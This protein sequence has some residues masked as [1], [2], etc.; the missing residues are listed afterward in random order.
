M[1]NYKFLPAES[2]FCSGFDKIGFIN[3]I[4]NK[5]SDLAN[6]SSFVVIAKNEQEAVHLVTDLGFLLKDKE[7]KY[8]PDL[9]VLAYDQE[10]PSSNLVSQRG[11]VFHSLMSNERVDI[12]VTTMG[13]LLRKNANKTHWV[14]SV[15][16]IEL[17]QIFELEKIKKGLNKINYN[18]QLIIEDFGQYS[19]RNNIF[20]VYPTGYADAF[21]VIISDSGVVS[22]IK[23]LNT[24]TQLSQPSDVKK[25]T[26][27]PVYEFPFNNDIIPEF[28]TKWRRTFNGLDGVI[29]ATQYKDVTAGVIPQ[30]ANFYMPF[31]CDGLVTLF[32]LISDDATFFFSRDSLESAKTIIDRIT[33]RYSDMLDIARGFILKPSELWLDETSLSHKLSKHN[34]Y[35]YSDNEDVNSADSISA[36]SN[37]ITRFP[38]IA[39]SVK[40]LKK[41]F[42]TA[43][44][45]LFVINSDV[46]NDSLSKLMSFMKLES[47][48]VQS[49]SE[50]E[51]KGGICVCRGLME[52]GFYDRKKSQLVITENEMYGM[53]LSQVVDYNEDLETVSVDSRYFSDLE[54]GDPIVHL[55][56]GIGRFLGFEVMDTGANL[57]VEMVKVAYQN[58][59]TKFIPPQDLDMISRYSGI[60]KDTAPFDE[61]H[62]K[63]WTKGLN[64]VVSDIA[65]ISGSLKQLHKNKQENWK[66]VPCDKPGFAYVKFCNEFPYP[67]TMDQDKAI[68]DVIAD[69]TSERVM[70][71]LVS[72]DVGYGK[73]EVAIR[74]AFV[75]A[76]TGYQVAVMAPTSIL[77]VQHYET[78]K[79]RFEGT[80]LK[81]ALLSGKGD[82]AK[83]EK[84]VL[85]GLEDGTVDIV[86]GTTRLLQKDVSIQALGLVITD[87]EHR[88]GV[89]DKEKL[90]NFSIGMNVLSMTATPIPRSMSLSMHN[91]R[92]LS[93]IATPPAKRL[94]IRTYAV[95]A[96]DRSISEAVNRELSRDGQVFVVHNRVKTIKE[97]AKEIAESY[98]NAVVKYAH[99]QMPDHEMDAI[100]AEFFEGKIDILVATTIIEVGI[101]V[102][103]ANTIIIDD[104]NMMGLAQLHQLRG[105]VGRSH[106]QAYAYLVRS[107]SITEEG[108]LRL[109]AMERVSGLG[110]GLELAKYDLEI[111]GAG[112]LLGESQS[113]SM[114]NV[115][116]DLYMNLLQWNLRQIDD[117]AIA[118]SALLSSGYEGKT[119]DDG[120]TRIVTEVKSGVPVSYI[121]DTASRFSVYHQILN[122]EIDKLDDIKR[123]LDDVYG[124]VPVEVESLMLIAKYSKLLAE[125]DVKNV[126]ATSIITTIKML[127]SNIVDV[128]KETQANLSELGYETQLTKGVNPNTSGV[129]Q[130]KV[131]VRVNYE[132]EAVSDKIHLNSTCSSITE[133]SFILEDIYLSALKANQDKIRNSH[134]DLAM[135]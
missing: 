104:A 55:K 46:R 120:R 98:P 69:L 62:S 97:R 84:Q 63:K 118:K 37:E 58:D 60:E 47:K 44:N 112:Q 32:D 124:P 18:E 6:D 34:V 102:P 86:I 30:G 134:V 36:V 81:V 35:V 1:N 67:L 74:A 70:D 31:F 41:W 77:A 75:A 3:L 39:A 56:Y 116:Y 40:A 65:A 19:F 68:K 13:A 24:S 25:I 125:V 27:M 82:A 109:L 42:T 52:N 121:S 101:D 131:K 88:F 51:S 110:K 76:Y 103:N 7:I 108:R 111:R 89:K 71:R 28:R 117:D 12:I 5:G 106:Y 80:N 17:G 21:R 54:I 72:G 90:G 10:M 79:K 128:T 29:G 61:Y 83:E 130:S 38:T 49:W 8:F 14:D 64:K 48:Q 92:D 15:V 132:S 45:V 9:E 127:S 123:E 96:G 43:E 53:I 105:R 100:I 115:G 119:F 126:S 114:M 59:V 4:A 113:G 66:G 57:K 95:D 50:F 87:E 93:I 23:L 107:E 78:F 133:L 11:A 91:I 85:K 129:V 73:T 16:D 26:A 135:V 20:D 2:H 33:F 94:S 22:E 122:A 99:G